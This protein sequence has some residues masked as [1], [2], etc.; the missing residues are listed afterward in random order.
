MLQRQLAIS[1][2][3][4]PSIAREQ[5][6]SMHFTLDGCTVYKSLPCNFSHKS[7]SIN[8]NDVHA[9]FKWLLARFYLL[10]MLHLFLRTI[11]LRLPMRPMASCQYLSMMIRLSQQTVAHGGLPDLYCDR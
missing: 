1:E 6:C 9:Q 11:P 3:H 5:L 10:L 7:M 8:R 4:S 2:L